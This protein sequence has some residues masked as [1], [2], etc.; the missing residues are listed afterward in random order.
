MDKNFKI[1]KDLLNIAMT[2]TWRSGMFLVKAL[3]ENTLY[4]N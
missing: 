2:L 1:L 3:K 4:I